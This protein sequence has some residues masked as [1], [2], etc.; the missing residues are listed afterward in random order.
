MDPLAGYFTLP[1]ASLIPPT[2]AWTWTWTSGTGHYRSHRG[3]E[4]H[5]IPLDYAFTNRG[6]EIDSYSDV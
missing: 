3:K 2:W 6:D 5:S 4:S 1:S